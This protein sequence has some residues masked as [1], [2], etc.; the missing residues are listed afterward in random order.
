MRI[1]IHILLIIM[2]IS[3]ASNSIDYAG[4]AL[5][6]DKPIMFKQG[7]KDGCSSG[8]EA[9]GSDM[10]KSKKSKEYAS[11]DLYKQGWDEGFDHCHNELQMERDLERM[12][13]HY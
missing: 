10:A 7:F 5:I 11:G 12:K 2:L 4:E 9:A 1:I 3:C 8:Y 6:K 13:S